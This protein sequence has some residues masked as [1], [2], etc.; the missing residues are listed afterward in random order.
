VLDVGRVACARERHG[1]RQHRE[2][3]HRDERAGSHRRLT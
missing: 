2:G 3:E 1:Q